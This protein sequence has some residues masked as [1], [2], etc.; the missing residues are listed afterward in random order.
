MN[1][2]EEK[3]LSEQIKENMENN[4]DFA[5]GVI[6]FY[7]AMADNGNADAQYEWAILLLEGEFV[8]ENYELALDYLYKSA[9]QGHENAETRYFSETAP[10]DD[11]RY[12]AWA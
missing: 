6:Q 3:T 9:E 7:K 10:D 2:I 4:P 8:E 5:A 11:G 12:D 1:I